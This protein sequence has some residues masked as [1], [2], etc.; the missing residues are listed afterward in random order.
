MPAVASASQWR[1]VVT[2]R[3]AAIKSAP[4]PS[5][6]DIAKARVMAETFNRGGR[7][8]VYDRRSRELTML[9]TWGNGEICW[10]V[11]CG[12]VL[13]PGTGEITEDRIFTEEQGGR[14]R[15]SNLMPS[16][17]PCNSSRQS[18]KVRR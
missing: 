6:E 8:N 15:L 13:H 16:C 17:G 4:R 11:W 2:M 9:Q 1:K 7:G 10:C 5:R 3:K 12:V 14:Y 18:I